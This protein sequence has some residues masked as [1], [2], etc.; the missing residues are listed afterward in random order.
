[1]TWQ[2]N[3]AFSSSF[4][5][6]TSKEDLTTK[7]PGNKQENIIHVFFYKCYWLELQ[8]RSPRVAPYTTS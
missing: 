1:M 6:I 2:I 8:C 7:V 3:L 4:I 5:V